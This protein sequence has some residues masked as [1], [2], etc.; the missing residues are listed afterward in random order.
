MPLNEESPNR[1]ESQSNRESGWLVRTAKSVLLRPDEGKSIDRKVISPMLCNRFNYSLLSKDPTGIGYALGVSSA[2]TGEGKTTVAANLA[3]SMALA[4]EKETV[5]VDFNL[6]QPRLHSVFGTGISP[7]LAEAIAEPTVYVSVTQVKH[8]YVLTAGNLGSMLFNNG[9]LPHSKTNGAFGAVA[10]AYLANFRDI[11]YSL[12]RDFDVIII[13]M[14]P[15]LDPEFP[16]LI[17]H[18]MNGLVL[19]VDS[20]KTTREDISNV[21]Q[22]VTRQRVL[23]FVLNRVSG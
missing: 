7:G 5:L 2:H 21:F 13:D 10:L 11:I 12:Q 3:V 15:V 23:G 22:R 20:K 14:G 1:E 17:T 19:V 4:G 9:Q 8:L 6:R 16:V 18:H